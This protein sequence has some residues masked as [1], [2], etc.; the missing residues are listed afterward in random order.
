MFTHTSSTIKKK[1]QGEA[2]RK[3]INVVEGRKTQGPPDR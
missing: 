3:C 1:A 2:E